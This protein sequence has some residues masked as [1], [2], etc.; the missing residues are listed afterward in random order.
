MLLAD[1]GSHGAWTAG[2]CGLLALVLL[3]AACGPGPSSGSSSNV[4]S[5]HVPTAVM[6]ISGSYLDGKLEVS[7][8]DW[9]IGRRRVDPDAAREEQTQE[10]ITARLLD[11]DGAIIIERHTSPA[12]SAR[13]SA[14]DIEEPGAF[15]LSLSTEHP[16]EVATLQVEAGG[17][18][19]EEH[20]G[21]AVSIE[22]GDVPDSLADPLEVAVGSDAPPEGVDAQLY[23]TQVT[24]R[25]L[26]VYDGTLHLDPTHYGAGPAQVIV[27]A[28]R[29]LAADID[30]ATTEIM[31][32][33]EEHLEVAVDRPLPITIEAGE[34]YL[35]LPVEV[36]RH[37]SPGEVRS[38]HPGSWT[39]SFTSDVDGSLDALNASDGHPELY[40]DTA[41]LTP[42]DHLITVRVT[43]NGE[44]AANEI[45]VRIPDS[46]G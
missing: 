3:L 18:L 24:G 43:G 31:V 42:G 9:R 8:A 21:D 45:P 14:G 39:F 37:V 32:D 23:G 22:L 40:I 33:F 19:H 7:G 17:R 26:D 6:Q 5:D 13:D 12:G 10:P 46:T 20:A 38:E 29:G 41:E 25:T 35:I 2:G 34:R 15:G 44:D 11:G 4:V 1:R 27:L 36:R 28:T 16:A 30:H